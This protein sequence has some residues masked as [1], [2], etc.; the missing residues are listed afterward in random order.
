MRKQF[1]ILG[2]A[3]VLLVVSLSACGGVSTPNNT[4]ASSSTG[5]SVTPTPTKALTWKTTHTF[6]GNGT[7]K[8]AI[9]TAPDDWKI[10]Y[11]C[12]F[13]NIGGVTADGALVVTVYGSDNSVLDLAVNATCK[14]GTAK[15]TGS[16]EEHQGGQV[17]LSVDG[18]GDWTIQ[19]QELK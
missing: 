18:T 15:T 14:N 6:T 19:V 16:T 11:T 17:Y 3:F 7:Q 13:Q 10:N 2:F 9:F 12:T 1:L 4:N 8:T 5:S